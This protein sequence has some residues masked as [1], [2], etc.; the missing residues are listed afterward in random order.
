MSLIAP[1][2]NFVIALPVQVLTAM[3]LVIACLPWAPDW[4]SAPVALSAWLVDKAVRW[5]ATPE[6]ASL[7]VPTPSRG[8]I[9]GFYTLVFA[10]LLALSARAS[11]RRKEL[12]L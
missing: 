11:R 3:G 9:V 1:V 7:T 6:W 2:A 4:L 5:L 12:A 8:A 10:A